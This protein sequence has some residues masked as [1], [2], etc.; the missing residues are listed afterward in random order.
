MQLPGHHRYRYSPISKRPVYEWPNGT[1]LAVN[2]CNNIEHFAYRAGLGSDNVSANAPQTQRNF[3][4]RDYGNRVGVWNYFDLLDEYGVPASHNVNSAAVGEFP[5]II[6]RIKSRG[7]ECIGHGR[8][9]AERQDQYWE[10]DEATLIAEAT[11]A[12]TAAM[13]AR[14]EGWLGPQRAES[15]VTV[16]LLKEAGYSYVLDWPADDQPFWMT[17]RAGRILSLPYPIELN[18]SAVCIARHHTPREFAQMVIDQFDEMLRT[19]AKRPLVFSLAVHTFI[20]GQPFRI[21]ALR[22]IFDHVLARRDDLWIARPRDIA[23]FYKELSDKN[24]ALP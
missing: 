14:P 15:T 5:D 18:D 17:T 8:T 16:D 21:A 11:E 20:S 12:L 3:A 23:H 1:R 19:S 24:G 22:E 10:A 7:D 6:E 4:W 9:N 2:F 13:G